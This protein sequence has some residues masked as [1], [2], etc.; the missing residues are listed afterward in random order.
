MSKKSRSY[1][2]QSDKNSDGDMDDQ[3]LAQMAALSQDPIHRLMTLSDKD[4]DLLVREELD[5]PVSSRVR[6]SCKGV[7]R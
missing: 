5:Q 7:N 2:V 1:N 6:K 4:I 3:L